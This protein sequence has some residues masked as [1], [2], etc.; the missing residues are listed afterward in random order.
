MGEPKPITRVAKGL[1]LT[2]IVLLVLFPFWTIL[3]T[4]ITAPEEVV[5]NGGWV[6]WPK[7]FSFRAYTDIFEGGQITHALL[8][9]L[10]VTVVGTATSLFATITLAY[11]LARPGVFGG[12]PVL[13]MVLFTFLFP[14]AMIPS[15][16]VVKE[17]GLL[18]SYASLVLPGLV[19]VFNLVIMRGFFQAVPG[20]LIEAAKLDGAGELRVL[21]RIVLP[22]SKSIV[23]VVGLFYAVSYWNAFFNAMIYTRQDMWPVQ[24]LM[25][26]YVTQGASLTENAQSETGIANSPQAVKM[27]VVIM[28]TLPIVIV[29]PF[30]QRFFAKGVLTGAI[31]S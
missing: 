27:A 24:T 10:G 25:R 31:K 1:A 15:Y 18:D 14:P 17:L 11:A 19:N 9:S 23:A 7:S 12:K 8:V 6:I 13:L 16:L 20:E 2:V 29:Y 21:T 26:L 28:A 22:L 4:S 30:I 3:A 5:A